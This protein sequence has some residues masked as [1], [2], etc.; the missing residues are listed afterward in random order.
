MNPRS[1]NCEADARTT[2]PSRQSSTQANAMAWWSVIQAI[3]FRFEFP[4]SRIYNIDKRGETIV[5]RTRK[6]VA[7]KG[8]KQVGA[9]TSAE[10]GVVGAISADGNAS[11]PLFIFPGKRYKNC[12]L[13][14]ESNRAIGTCNESG[15]INE[16]VFL[17]FIDHIIKYSA[18][19]VQ[20]PILIILYNH[21]SYCSSSVVEKAKDSGIA[22][23][24]LSPHTS[25]KLQ[26]LN[27]SVLGPLKVFHGNAVDEWLRSHPGKMVSLYDISKIVTTALNLGF[28]RHNVVAEFAATG[29]YPLNKNMFGNSNFMPSAVTERREREIEIAEPSC[30]TS[31]MR[32]ETSAYP[33]TRTNGLNVGISTVEMLISS[34]TT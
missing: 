33:S 31:S 7:A 34:N 11:S 17:E 27:V 29:I 20:E 5:A 18:C 8:K 3:T 9:N 13:N 26:P 32:N 2:T 24:T 6:V 21:Y 22:S 1:I 14:G 15:L 10:R 23:L 16:S 28:S 12:V 30:S 4:S 19:T 25:H